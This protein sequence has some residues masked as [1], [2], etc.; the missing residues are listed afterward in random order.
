MVG[1]I[2]LHDALCLLVSRVPHVELA[3]FKWK[4][5]NHPPCSPGISSRYFH[6]LGLMKKRLKRKRFNSDDKIKNDVTD[7]VPSRLQELWEQ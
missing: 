4:Q 5:F 3:K 7:F 1:V 2:L 6:V